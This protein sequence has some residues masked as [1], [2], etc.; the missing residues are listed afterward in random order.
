M[1]VRVGYLPERLLSDELARLRAGLA[2]EVMPGPR[3]G[4]FENFKHLVNAW[5][6]GSRNCSISCLTTMWNGSD[7][8]PGLWLSAWGHFE[9]TVARTWRYFARNGITA[10]TVI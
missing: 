2:I 10:R 5:G 4:A 9:C 3:S 7:S 6:P 1:T 8:S